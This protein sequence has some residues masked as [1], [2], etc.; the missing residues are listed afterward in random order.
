MKITS[1]ILKRANRQIFIDGSGF[2]QRDGGLTATQQ[3]K[4]GQ[5]GEY[6]ITLNYIN[7]DGTSDQ[8]VVRDRYLDGTCTFVVDKLGGIHYTT[9]GSKTA[10]KGREVATSPSRR[11][12][13]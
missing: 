8:K 4:S 7:N 11:M 5:D 10:P 3:L 1:M 13:A 9:T 6:T 2:V 12:Y